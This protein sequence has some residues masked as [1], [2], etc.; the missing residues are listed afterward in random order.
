MLK[1]TECLFFL[2]LS[3]ST[4]TNLFP[5]ALKDFVITTERR[6]SWLD[7]LSVT[8]INKTCSLLGYKWVK[9]K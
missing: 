4:L 7:V 2:I 1:K 9:F 8:R 3:S 6:F 5:E